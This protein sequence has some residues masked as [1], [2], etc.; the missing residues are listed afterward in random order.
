MVF[1]IKRPASK[2]FFQLSFEGF[3]PQGRNKFEQFVNIWVEFFRSILEYMWDKI[4]DLLYMIGALVYFLFQLPSFAKSF[5]VKKLIWSRG[6]LGRPLAFV[7]VVT[8]SL[9]V[10]MIGEVKSSYDFIASPQVKA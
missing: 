4:V 7:T 9:G 5:I 2:R 3:R 10:F 1:T 6:K 8:A